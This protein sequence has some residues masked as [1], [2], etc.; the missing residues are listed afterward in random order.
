M[1][2]L[3]LLFA[4]LVSLVICAPAQALII[5]PNWIKFHPDT[6]EV[7]GGA[8]ATIT[9]IS[10]GVRIVM[11]VT[12][13]PNGSQDITE[14]YFNVGSDTLL[15]MGTNYQHVGTDVIATEIN[16][17]D[18]ADGDGVFDLHFSFATTGSN[19][20]T[21]LKTSTYDIFQTGLT[22]DAFESLSSPR[23]GAGPFVSAIK[24]GEA[25]WAETSQSVTVPE[26]LTMLLLG[27][28]LIG[29]A[30]VRRF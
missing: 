12:N 22:A 28:G 10:G 3:V 2:K 13:F 25:F 24:N 26:P 17:Q 18:Q 19:T 4:L 20:F 30:G 6:K 5:G 15:G 7:I 11:D 8:T 14:W 27:F 29:L 9:N 21:L 1:R 23:G 16:L